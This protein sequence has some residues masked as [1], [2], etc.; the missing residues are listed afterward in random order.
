M[1]TIIYKTPEI[2]F[3]TY[4]NDWLPFVCEDP[5][6]Y[7][8]ALT[9]V[10]TNCEQYLLDEWKVQKKTIEYWIPGTE[11]ERLSKK[12]K[13][14]FIWAVF[15][16]IPKKYSI[17]DLSVDNNF[18]I[19]GNSN[20][21]EDVNTKYIDESIFEIIA[22]DSSFFII[23]SDDNEIHNRFKEKYENAKDIKEIV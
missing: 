8:F 10:E 3:Y 18:Y 6:K 11:L 23:Q 15:S 12:T 14:Q 19:D 17:E 20:I 16:A 9:E 7:N 22:F 13:I 21:C 2:D 5:S 1:K 4:L